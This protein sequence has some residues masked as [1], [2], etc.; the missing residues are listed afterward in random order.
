MNRAQMERRRVQRGAPGNVER[1]AGHR[2]AA[3]HQN[4]LARRHLV[5]NAPLFRKS[6]GTFTAGGLLG[7]TTRIKLF[8]VGLLVRVILKVHINYT[9]GVAPATLSPFGAFNAISRIKLVDFDGSD[10]ISCSGR[11]LH[12]RNIVRTGKN[13][14]MNES[15]GTATF[16]NPSVP[17]AVGAQEATFFLEVPVCYNLER[18][19]LRGMM[20]MQTAV[21][22]V[23]VNIDWATLLHTAADDNFV[24]NGA[25]GTTVAGVTF[26]VDA[27]QEYFLPQADRGTVHLPKQDLLT[28]Y[29]I[30]GNNVSTT[31][32][33]AGAE[34]LVNLPNVREVIGA[35]HIYR[36]TSQLPAFANDFSSIRLI[37]NGNNVIE[38]S[39]DILQYYRQRR[40]LRG[41]VAYDIAANAGAPNGV[42]FFNWFRNP[43]KTWLYGNVQQGFT[44]RTAPVATTDLETTWESFY[45]KGTVLP[46]LGQS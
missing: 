22:E 38:E 1:R 42:Y 44:P 28:V 19:D 26:T 15:V 23:S 45:Q 3:M 17:V 13:L 33:A 35:Y 30:A 43:I 37:A 24:F 5:H 20:L 31:D 7:Q 36:W 11:Q 29:E 40:H 46:G 14:G 21:G 25:A 39:T 10:R 2:A 27:W 4:A 41:D 12:L 6:L 9:L 32:F 16:T 34:K 8:N 18:N